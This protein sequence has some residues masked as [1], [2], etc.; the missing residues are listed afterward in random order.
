MSATDLD[1]RLAAAQAR[2]ASQSG[3]MT[4]GTR[5]TSNKKREAPFIASAVAFAGWASIVSGF[6]LFFMYMEPRGYSGGYMLSFES[7]SFLL[8]GVFWGVMLLGFAKVI[9]LLNVI[10][11]N[12]R[13]N[14]QTSE[15]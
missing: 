7:F 10:A 13:P 15:G 11:N 3:T 6:L 9:T 1:Q 14:G 2:A 5:S 12:T 8:I 4:S